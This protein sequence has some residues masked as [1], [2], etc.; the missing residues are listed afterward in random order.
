MSQAWYIYPRIDNFGHYP[1][2]VGL[3]AKPDSNIDCPAGTPITALASGTVTSVRLQPWG[4][5]AWSITVRLDQ[6]LNEV[7][8]HMAYNYVESPQVSAGQH[9]AFGD[10]LASAG[11]P[12]GIGTSFALC[13]S[14]VYGTSTQNSPFRGTYINPALNPVPFLDSL[15][16]GSGGQSNASGSPAA[17]NPMASL[18][19]T[20]LTEV[21]VPG[22]ALSA[23]NNQSLTYIGAGI[24]GATLLAGAGILFLF[25]GGL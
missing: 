6:A 20:V 10:T 21:G 11:N 3:Y 14:D 4:P 1:D 25:T 9:V 18:A 17:S 24:I 23:L 19:T 13:D 12:Y 5:L 7:A 16:S 22:A 2:P 8:T 15:K